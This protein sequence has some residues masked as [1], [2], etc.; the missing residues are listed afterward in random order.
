MRK[1]LG[2]LV[3][4]GGVAGL[5]LW[6][7]NHQAKTIEANITA[8]AN[9]ILDGNTSDVDVSVS[10]R[11]I[12]VTG[13]ATH[14]EEHAALISELNKIEGRRLVRNE[15]DVSVAETDAAETEDISDEAEAVETETV[16]AEAVE[17]ETEVVEQ[18]VATE[19]TD[20]V[21]MAEEAAVAE[22]EE[23]EPLPTV[24]PYTLSASRENGVTT[25][26]GHVADEDLRASLSDMDVDGSNDL[27]LAQGAPEQWA[28]A[29]TSGVKALNSLENGTLDIQDTRLDLS[30]TAF[31]PDERSE[32]LEHLSALPS[33]FDNTPAIEMRDDGTPP[34]FQVAWD[35]GQGASVT[36]KL[37]KSLDADGVARALDLDRV[38]SSARNALFEHGQGDAARSVLSG[39]SDWLIQ[40]ERAELDFDNGD[41]GLIAMPSP[42]SDEEL[43]TLSLSDSL[44]DTDINL[45]D[46][47]DLPEEGTIRQNAATGEKEQLTDGYWLPHREFTADVS[48]CTRQ[49]E[50]ALET[51]KINFVTGSARLDA[52]AIS[53]INQ[54]AAVVRRCVDGT[55]LIL[56][57]GG[58][59]DNVGSDA[60]NQTLSLE[61]AQ[62]VKQALE[63]RNIPSAPMDAIG[64]GESQPIADNSTEEGRAANR[65]T[66]ISWSDSE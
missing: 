65:R 44:P 32:A 17:A 4:I 46:V 9:D 23:A 28:S 54:L 2:T 3:L 41:S 33:A 38:D 43:V 66:S 27:T 36:G 57:L 62:A 21:E 1:I 51:H 24:S 49:S 52:R 22:A 12:T 55:T 35:A 64:Y 61:R 6:G 56:E 53:A 15:V 10:G 63:N 25:V 59:T 58:H 13:V 19:D 16:E 31:G 40:L 30:G 45:I 60:F 50:V 14:D 18:A 20:V 29:V 48:T 11:D 47:A 34:D 39:L 8:K 42:G 26:E 7:A 37:P 5:G